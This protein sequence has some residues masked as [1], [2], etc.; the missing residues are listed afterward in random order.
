MMSTQ[1]PP[2][3]ALTRGIVG[4]WQQLF[5]IEGDFMTMLMV[6]A[7][8]II[9]ALSLQQV[10]WRLVMP[11]IL[12]GIVL[13]VI[14]GFLLARSRYNVFFAMGISFLYSMAYAVF[15]LTVYTT[16]KPFSGIVPTIQQLIV[17]L[18][19]IFLGHLD[20]DPIVLILFDLTL[21]WL[22]SY[23]AAWHMFRI[24]HAFR[25]VLPSGLVI[26]INNVFYSDEEALVPHLAAYTLVV[27]MLVMRSNLDRYI[28]DWY[29][30]KLYIRGDRQV[31]R[32]LQIT[33]MILVCLVVGLA[34]IIPTKN[35][36]T[37][38]DQFQESMSLG[39][40]ITI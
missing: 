16:G 39:V 28:R 31:Y 20:S 14:L 13:S 30:R 10:G 6:I 9:P 26:I 34:W 23:D 1:P 11:I 36:Q 22:I 2:D 33:G 8:S 19:A 27:L 18:E 3:V 35:I 21:F 7:L 29:R 4:I 24:N 32:Y 38:L 17:E 40:F 37:R 12:T 5:P 25:A 15:A